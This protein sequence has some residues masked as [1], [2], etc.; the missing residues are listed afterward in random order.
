MLI[1]DLKARNFPFQVPSD[2]LNDQAFIATLAQA[3]SIGPSSY[4]T[5]APVASLAA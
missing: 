1:A 5:E 2:A 3:Y 4:P